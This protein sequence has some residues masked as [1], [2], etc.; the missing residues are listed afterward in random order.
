[1]EKCTNAKNKIDVLARMI[2][3][4]NVVYMNGDRINI[5][6]IDMD[7]HIGLRVQKG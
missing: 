7:L 1:M 4:L 6:E 2:A 5:P 3:V